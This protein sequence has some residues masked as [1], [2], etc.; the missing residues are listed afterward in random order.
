VGGGPVYSISSEVRLEDCR[1]KTY[2]ALSADHLLAVELRGKGL[3][4]WLD[5]TTTE[6][7]NKVESRLL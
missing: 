6:T 3:E 5:D 1:G 7:E 2:V 4:R